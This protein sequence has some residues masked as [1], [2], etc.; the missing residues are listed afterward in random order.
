ME[1]KKKMVHGTATVKAL[2]FAHR[3]SVRSPS[4]L[5]AAIT[6]SRSGGA[7]NFPSKHAT[8]KKC[9]LYEYK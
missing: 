8:R 3:R 9:F 2:D 6:Q 1:E 4:S 5:H 7:A